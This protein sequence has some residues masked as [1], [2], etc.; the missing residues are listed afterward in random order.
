MEMCISLSGISACFL[1]LED[2]IFWY[3][4][5]GSSSYK[6]G[7]DKNILG[8]AKGKPF[9]FCLGAVSNIGFSPTIKD[10]MGH[11]GKTRKKF[12]L[13]W[14]CCYANH[15]GYL[16]WITMTSLS[17]NCCFDVAINIGA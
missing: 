4:Q 16:Q 17:R 12:E 2:C 3:F 8:F 14:S 1:T 13:W 6:A 10:T 5:C 9:S 11:H 15:H 7:Y